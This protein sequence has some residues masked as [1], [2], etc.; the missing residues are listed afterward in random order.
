MNPIIKNPMPVA[1]AILANSVLNGYH[2]IKPFCNLTFETFMIWL[3]AFLHQICRIFD[4][5]S[6]R[7]YYPSIYV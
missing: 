6:Q 2:Y 4:K 5:L 1:R 3:S 7:L